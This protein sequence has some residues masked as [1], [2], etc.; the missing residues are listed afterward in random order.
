MNRQV[1]EDAKQ[2]EVTKG[3]EDNEA[4]KNII[5]VKATCNPKEAKVYYC[6]R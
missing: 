4:E 2:R 3:S 6:S 1:E 5:E